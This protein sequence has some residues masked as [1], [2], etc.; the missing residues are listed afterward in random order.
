FVAGLINYRRIPRIIWPTS[1]GFVFGL[2]QAGLGGAVVK[3]ELPAGLVA[4]HLSLAL[5]ILT[6]LLLLATT[7]FSI[8]KPLPRLPVGTQFGRIAAMA[9][10]ATLALML[11]GSYVS[12]AGYGLA[13]SGWPLCNNQVVPNTHAMSVQIHFLHRFLALTVGLLIAG[14]LYSSWRTRHEA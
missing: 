12:G 6:L 14:L 1:V 5:T 8:D 4:L 11:V 3:N 10:I 9:S 13:C 2:V 7:A